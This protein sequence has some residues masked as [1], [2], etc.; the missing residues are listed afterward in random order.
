M[1]CT[2][3]GNQLPEGSRFCTRCGTPVQ[4]FP[5]IQPKPQPQAP[6]YQQPQYQA[7]VPPQLAQYQ[8]PQYQA[9]VPPQPAQYQQPQ[10]QAPV[11]PQPAQYQQ[12]QYQAPVQPQPVYQ[13]VE[14]APVPEPVVEIPEPPV[15]EIPKDAEP[16]GASFFDEP[17]VPEVPT[18]PE[19]TLP[20]PQ[21]PDYSSSIFDEP[22]EPQYE[23]PTVPLYK[24]AAPQVP[25]YE[26]P[27]AAPQ[28][29]EAPKPEVYAP[30]PQPAAEPRPVRKNSSS[31]SINVLFLGAAL[32]PL[33]MLVLWFIKCFEDQTLSIFSVYAAAGKSHTFY[34]IL[35][36][37]GIA[38]LALS[39]LFLILPG[40]GL[41][42]SKL[43]PILA[44]FFTLA[45]LI[46]GGYVV[47]E[48]LGAGHTFA[49]VPTVAYCF[50]GVGLLGIIVD[51][52]VLVK[53]LSQEAKA[54]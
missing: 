39:I 24:P 10:Y 26:Q 36:W 6:Q 25:K 5:S 23:E 21:E 32:F 50:M 40:I 14:P 53:G 9:P 46:A 13:P 3:C 44:L 54:A 4:P 30:R 37:A 28:T 35:N 27:A 17:E 20:E 42:K 7:P 38:L 11:Q 2:R 33:L 34:L 43:L 15:P 19:V 48:Y 45:A 29:Y 8:Q 41:L 49:E 47:Y 12:P 51:F 16:Q 52:I 22:Q 18:Q 1:F 31:A